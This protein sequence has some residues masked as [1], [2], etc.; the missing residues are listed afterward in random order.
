LPLPGCGINPFETDNLLDATQRHLSEDWNTVVQVQNGTATPGANLPSQLHAVDNPTHTKQNTAGSVIVRSYLPYVSCST[1]GEISTC[2]SPPAGNPQAYAILRDVNTGCA[3]SATWLEE[4]AQLVYAPNSTNHQPP[5]PP[6]CALPSPSTLCNAILSVADLS[7]GVSNWLSTSQAGQHK[8]Y[9]EVTGEAC[10]ATASP[11]AIPSPAFPNEVAW[12]RGPEWVGTPGPDDAY[13]GGAISS[14]DLTNVAQGAELLLFQFQLPAMP[15]TPCVTPTVCELSG[16]EQLRYWSMTF[17]YQTTS[18]SQQSYIANPDG[19]DTGATLDYA[20]LVSVADAALAPCPPGT[21]PCTVNLFVNVGNSALPT[22]LAYQTAPGTGIVLGVAP[23]QNSTGDNGGFTLWSVSG[24]SGVY[25]RV[26]DLTQISNFTNNVCPQNTPVTCNLPLLL[27][28]RTTLPNTGTNTF[29]CAGQAVP[30]STVEYT[31]SGGLMGAYVPQVTYWNP[32][33]ALPTLSSSLSSHC[34]EL[35]TNAVPL[36]NNP[37]N[38]PSTP[39]L[40]NWPQQYWTGTNPTGL[41]TVLNCGAT[42]ELDPEIFFVGTQF[43]TQTALQYEGTPPGYNCATQSAPPGNPCTQ[44]ILQST[45][46]TEGLSA[47]QPGTP[48]TIVGKNFGQ[49]PAATVPQLTLPAALTNPLYLEITDCPSNGSCPPY[50]WTTSSTSCQVYIANWTNWS[51][52][53]V[54]NLTTSAFNGYEPSLPLSPLADVNY[55]TFQPGSSCQIA[56]GDVLGFT[57][58]NPQSGGSTT[59]SPTVTVSGAGTAPL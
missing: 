45:Q 27:T 37:Y 26:L 35:P 41:T 59:M 8:V 44:I 49:L 16:N 20:S 39:A 6:N 33:T 3:Y 11:S 36:Y 19:I 38:S 34:G 23:Y 17:S 50:K 42:T 54:A 47:W 10:Y 30:F 51:I 9:G 5:T 2:T 29:S 24:A 58:T 56:A 46:T 12:T 25:T 13:I 48:I 40:L 1:P 28:I 57:V 4:T 52:S 32:T 53:L 31:A 7:E 15:D 55:E 21:A 18:G 43:S 14:G 22:N